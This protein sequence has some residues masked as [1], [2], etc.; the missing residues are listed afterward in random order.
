MTENPERTEFQWSY[1]PKGFFEAPYRYSDGEYDILIDEGKVVATLRTPQDP[2]DSALE[3][4]IENAV[5][6]IFKTRKL[7]L[8]A[9]YELKGVSLHQYSK[10]TKNVA[11]RLASASTI[12]MAGRA[13]LIL[14]DA[15]GNVVKDSKA[16]RISE[17]TTMLDSL[18]PKLARSPLLQ[19]L[20]ESYCRAVDDPSDEFTHL[21]EIRDALKTH[22]G[23]EMKA[24]NALS[25]SKNEWQR[26]GVLACV[27]P[28]EEGRHRGQHPS[29]RRNATAQELNEA[30]RLV[31]GWIQSLRIRSK[32]IKKFKPGRPPATGPP[33][34]GN[35]FFFPNTRSS[36]FE[37]AAGLPSLMTWP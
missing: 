17:H 2:V 31:L 34:N 10:K 33:I 30:R 7:I 18:V 37:A 5:R 27:E 6:N 24:R 32:G 12:V 21:Y 29:G 28:R 36:V 14:K 35:Y 22:F 25:I 19:I 8:H 4:R 15:H 26:L 13:D 9:P 1:E 11:I 23:E 16:E 3:Q 20:L